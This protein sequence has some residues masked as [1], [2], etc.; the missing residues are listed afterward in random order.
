MNG[1]PSHFQIT[2]KH[3][4]ERTA[5]RGRSCLRAAPKSKLYE[6]CSR[7]AA[8]FIVDPDRINARFT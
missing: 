4:R 2:K 6:Q 3:V 7:V 1:L 8:K 5:Q